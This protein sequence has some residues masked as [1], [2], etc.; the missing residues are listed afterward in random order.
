M[1]TFK[2]I[3]RKLIHQGKII[4]YYTDIIKVPNGNI[5]EWDYI[6][7]KGA[8]AVVPV[9]PDG[10]ILMVK[11]YRN[12][13]ERYTVEIPAGGLN[14][15]LEDPLLAA[16]R[17]L[18]E[19][20]GFAA[21]RLELLICINTTVAFCNEMIS[22]YVAF[23]DGEGGAQDL[24]EDEFI[25]VEAYHVEQ[26]IQMIYDCEITDSKTISAILAYKNKFLEPNA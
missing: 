13:L 7:H 23:I 4:D 5:V 10:R 15:S 21:E 26:L 19:E 22:V 25:N 1:E 24:D 12:A 18:K 6:H 8:A 2:R 9:M 16:K 3:E 14:G 11:Q 20:T 17:E